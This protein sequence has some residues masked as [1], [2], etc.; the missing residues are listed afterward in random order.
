M[1]TVTTDK[2]KITLMINQISYF[3]DIEYFEWRQE[4]NKG[5]NCVIQ[6]HNEGYFCVQETYEQ[7]L[8]LINNALK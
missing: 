8:A 7:V 3:T 2:G 5:A 4:Q 6:M 1:I